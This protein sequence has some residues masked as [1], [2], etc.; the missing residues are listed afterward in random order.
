MV[1]HFGL[2][3]WGKL[4]GL[5]LLLLF[6][7]LLRLFLPLLCLFLRL[8]HSASSIAYLGR[9]FVECSA[10]NAI[11]NIVPRLQNT[12]CWVELQG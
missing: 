3:D 7:Q 2:S 4:A 8:L 5:Y 9:L 1:S 6:L 10:N 12:E 11:S